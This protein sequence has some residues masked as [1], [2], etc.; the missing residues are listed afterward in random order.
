MLHSLAPYKLNDVSFRGEAQ[1]ICAFEASTFIRNT[2]CFPHAFCIL[3]ENFQYPIAP[4]KK[5]V[6]YKWV[7]LH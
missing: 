1:I 3:T 7:H 2:A 4:A 6:M 5:V